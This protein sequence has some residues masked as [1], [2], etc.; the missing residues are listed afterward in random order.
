M[1]EAELLAVGESLLAISPGHPTMLVLPRGDTLTKSYNSSDLFVTTPIKDSFGNEIHP[2]SN[3]VLSENNAVYLAA[4]SMKSN[5]SASQNTMENVVKVCLYEIRDAGEVFIKE[6]IGSS[7][8]LD[9]RGNLQLVML[10]GRPYYLVRV[11]KDE[12]QQIWSGIPTEA[13]M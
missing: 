11:G 2:L 13:E 7:A 4:L 12:K 8:E 10:S 6:T 1:N 3:A 5:N 9:I